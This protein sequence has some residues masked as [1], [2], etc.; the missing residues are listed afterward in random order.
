MEGHSAP[1]NRGSDRGIS[2]EGHSALCNRGFY[3]GINMEGHSAPC[4]RGSNR[5]INI[6]GVSAPCNRGS[7]TT[8][9]R[10]VLRS[11]QI[12]QQ[13]IRYQGVAVLSI[14]SLQGR[15]LAS[16]LGEVALLDR[17]GIPTACHPVR[18]LFFMNLCLT[19]CWLYSN[20]RPVVFSLGYAYRWG[21]AYK[22]RR[23]TGCVKLK[24][25]NIS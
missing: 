12:V 2:M 14:L 18:L 16:Y 9:S 22:R 25:R 23:L 20:L 3:R 4:N 5:G 7:Y 24:K 11:M 21:Y 13:Q 8:P 19:C 6:E 15:A 10:E 17:K 1:C